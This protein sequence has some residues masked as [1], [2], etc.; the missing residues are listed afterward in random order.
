MQGRRWVKPAVLVVF[1]LAGVVAVLTVGVPPI[2]QIRDWVVAAGWAAPLAFTL[3]YAALCIVPAPASVLSIGAG[4]LFGLP[5][6]LATVLVGAVAGAVGA[7]ALSRGLG[8][9]AVADVGGARLARLDA[10]LR[11]RGLLAM[12]SVRLVPVLPFAALNYACGL[13]AIRLRDYAAG[14]FL[15]ILPGATAFVAIGA[16]G[17]QPG[18]VPFLVAVGG[19]VLL[20]GGGAIAARR[21]RAATTV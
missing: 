18:S 2:G 21:S 20:L 5:V 1:V 15:G 9:S 14:T 3:L 12:I 19:L 13:T 8:R 6:G 17:A 10:L 7:F 16:Y 11:R 4:V